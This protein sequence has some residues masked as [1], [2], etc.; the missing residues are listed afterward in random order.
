[1]TIR[2]INAE[3]KRSITNYKRMGIAIELLENGTIEVRQERLLNNYILNRQELRERAKAIFPDAD[4]VA[5]TYAPDIDHIDAKW[6]TKNMKEF[7]LLEE[8][9]GRQLAWDAE[10]LKPILH[11][12]AKLTK[13][14]KAALY[15]Y[16]MCYELNR[17]FRR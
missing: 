1:M 14:Q 2:T 4:L 15:F 16:F 5:V 10:S 9:I 3:Q 13:E 12:G 6:I 11:E 17:D 8:D 7:G